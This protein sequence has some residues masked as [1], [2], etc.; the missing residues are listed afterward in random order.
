MRPIIGNFKDL[1]RTTI[2]K[3]SNS[4]MSER[5]SE[6][7]LYQVEIIEDPTSFTKSLPP[8]EEA[9]FMVVVSNPV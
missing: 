5:E 1:P 3:D 7:N 9:S 2:N 6:R 8:F 4:T